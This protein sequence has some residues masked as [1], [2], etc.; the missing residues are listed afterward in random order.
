MCNYSL[1]KIHYFIF[2]L[3]FFLF[4]NFLDINECE[5]ENGGCEELCINI[6]GSFNCGCR[7]NKKKIVM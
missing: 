3:L 5:I 6:D 7:W 4:F 1:Y 2:V